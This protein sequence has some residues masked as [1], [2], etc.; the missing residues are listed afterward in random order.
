MNNKI[1]L[2]RKNIEQALNSDEILDVFDRVAA[3]RGIEK[4]GK[5]KKDLISVPK[6][7]LLDFR[8]D[9]SDY[10]ETP[11]IIQ[12]PVK[13][14]HVVRTLRSK[15]RHRGRKSVNKV[16]ISKYIEIDG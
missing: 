9:F 8:P 6:E 7:D 10:D 14:S 3:K 13:K 15:S 12:R 11:R 1:E 2:W 5:F 4:T 16:A